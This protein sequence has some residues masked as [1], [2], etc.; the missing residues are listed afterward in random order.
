MTDYEVGLIQ[1]ENLTLEQINWLRYC[2]EHNCKGDETRRRREYPSRPEEA[3]EASGADILDPAIL[4]KWSKEAEKTPP[5][6]KGR[7]IAREIRPGQLMVSFDSMDRTGKIEIYDYPDSHCRYVMGLD[8]SQGVEG[9]DWTV[10]VVL[11]VD[12]GDQVA[13]FRATIDPDLA[14]DQVEWLGIFYNNAYTIIEVNGGYGWPYV[15]HLEDRGTLPMY[16]RKA[17][18]RKT[19]QYLK[20]PGWDTTMKTRPLIITELKEAV[21]KEKIHL[22]SIETL[23]ECRSLWENETGKIEARP[24]KHDD[25]PFA[26]G[27]AQICRNE[28]LGVQREKE[29]EERLSKDFVRRLNLMSS[30][31]KRDEK[32]KIDSFIPVKKKH[33]HVTGVRKDKRRSVI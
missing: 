3:F 19:K 13:E 18:D 5:K 22:R 30:R 23:K 24:G 9:G 10:A 25:G 32:K 26:V 31:R 14:V 12:T 28:M 33:V 8:P 16:E 1:T 17:Y 20:R 11:D 6:D 27:I 29:E 2:L 7:M 4:S 21:R 15:R